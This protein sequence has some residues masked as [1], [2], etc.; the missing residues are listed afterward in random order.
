MLPRRVAGSLRKWGGSMATLS[1]LPVSDLRLRGTSRVGAVD[2]GRGRHWDGWQ[3]LTSVVSLALESRV[4]TEMVERGFPSSWVWLVGGSVGRAQH[5][6]K[7]RPGEGSQVPSTCPYN[8]SK[9]K[10]QKTSN[11]PGKEK[12]K[13]K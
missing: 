1:A 7:K 12:N 2:A 9:I 5:M 11:A 10:K 8:R 4:G 3:L 13:L 6:G